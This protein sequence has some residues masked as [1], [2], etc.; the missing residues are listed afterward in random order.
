VLLLYLKQ[1]RLKLMK[2]LRLRCLLPLL[3]TLK[4]M[5]NQHLLETLWHL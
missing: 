2:L 3:L 1:L 4:Q 5:L